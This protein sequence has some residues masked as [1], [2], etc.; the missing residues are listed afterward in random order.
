VI[1]IDLILIAAALALVLLVWTAIRHLMLGVPFVPAPGR[2]IGVALEQLRLQP[3][4]VF[5]DLGAGDG[6]VLI[7]AVRRVPGVTARGVE[8]VWPVWLAGRLRILLWRSKAALQY[9]DARTATI[10]DVTA[11]FLYVTPA[12]LAELAPKLQR[13]LSPGAR[14]VSVAFPLPG[15]TPLAQ[16]PVETWRGRQTVWL[17][18]R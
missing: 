2:S 17:Y 11:V 5:C 7:E 4:D 15:F 6:R 10:E 8:A 13:E 9:G 1:F 16:V 12:L 14:I 3:S 18:A